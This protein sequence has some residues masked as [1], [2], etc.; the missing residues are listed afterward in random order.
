MSA[1]GIGGTT[2]A[3]MQPDYI[4]LNNPE[5]M[6]EAAKTS[7]PKPESNINVILAHPEEYV[8]FAA[9]VGQK[10]VYQSL[11]DRPA[12]P[13][14]FKARYVSAPPIRGEAEWN[15]IYD[16]IRG[17]LPANLRA[18]LD[19]DRTKEMPDR[20]PYLVAIEHFMQFAT[21]VQ[22]VLLGFSTSYVP[23]TESAR[24][25][26]ATYEGLPA[27]MKTGLSTDSREML[28]HA[29][30]LISQVGSNNPNYE[31]WVQGLN[32]YEEVLNHLGR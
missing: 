27:L 14:L 20:D 19:A 21:D 26:S 29:R 12:L 31:V 13:P 28:G 4:D 9:Q 7:P 25:A 17:R 22:Y 6:K 24:I 5:T 10:G 15:R 8:P 16:E 18:R 30:E 32:Q 23:D 3:P 1:Y 11:P 2:N